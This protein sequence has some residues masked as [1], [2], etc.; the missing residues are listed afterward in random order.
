M[1]NER[2]SQVDALSGKTPPSANISESISSIKDLIAE[3]RTYVNRVKYC[4]NICLF[5]MTAM[6]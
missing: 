5:W 4:L 1:L 3:T 6:I 2:I